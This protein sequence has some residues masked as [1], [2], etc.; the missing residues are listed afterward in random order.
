[1]M[2]KLAVLSLT[3]AGFAFSAVGCASHEANQSSDTPTPMTASTSVDAQA[4]T[5]VV[6]TSANVDASLGQ[7]A[8]TLT[9]NTTAT[10][11]P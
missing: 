4:Q 11:A 2:K 6:S 9:T 3:V 1:M 8:T 7:Q 10:N 5:P